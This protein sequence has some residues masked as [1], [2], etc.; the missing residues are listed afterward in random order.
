MIYATL[1]WMFDILKIIQKKA[2]F[3]SGHWSRVYRISAINSNHLYR[4]YMLN[5]FLSALHI[6]TYYN[7]PVTDKEIK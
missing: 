7:I 3:A 2:N 5:K 6:L 4:T 1:I